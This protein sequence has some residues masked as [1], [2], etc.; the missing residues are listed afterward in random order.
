MHEYLN[1]RRRCRHKLFSVK[2]LALYIRNITYINE[3]LRF[4]L[5]AG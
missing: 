1:F 4:K 2:Y 3:V 5:F